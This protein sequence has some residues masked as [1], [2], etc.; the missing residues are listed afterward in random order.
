MDLSIMVLASASVPLGLVALVDF[1][2]ERRVK[3]LFGMTSAVWSAS[4][5]VLV[6]IGV[7]G[8][9]FF[10][11]LLMILI[12]SSFLQGRRGGGRSQYVKA[13]SLSLLLILITLGLVLL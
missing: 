3:G 5:V 6:Y 8:I 9:V 4:G 10:P 1:L 2:S 7:P 11:G 13:L 12:L